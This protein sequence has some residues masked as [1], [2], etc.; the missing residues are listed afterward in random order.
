M[1]KFKIWFSKLFCKE[2]V[3]YSKLLKMLLKTTVFNDFSDFD[4]FKDRILK[5]D[6]RF[7]SELVKEDKYIPDMEESKSDYVNPKIEEAYYG[8]ESYK[9]EM[10]K[11]LFILFYSEIEI[12]LKRILSTYDWSFRIGKKRI[13]SFDFPN[14]IKAFKKLFEVNIKGIENFSDFDELRLLNN[15]LKH[16]VFVNRKLQGRNPDR[17]HK[18]NPIDLT[19]DDLERLLTKSKEFYK[20]LLDELKKKLAEN[21]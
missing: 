4:N 9:K 14:I 17:W 6:L 3:L 21:Q 20:N 5:E 18:G 19:K 8:H 1:L 11:A 10:F 12:K 16:G 13:S 15:C 2:H 7:D